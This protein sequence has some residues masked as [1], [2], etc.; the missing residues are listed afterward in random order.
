MAEQKVLVRNQ[1]KQLRLRNRKLL[2]ERIC[3]V[4]NTRQHTFALC[5]AKEAVQPNLA[6]VRRVEWS[7]WPVRIF[8]VQMATCTIMVMIMMITITSINSN[9]QIFSC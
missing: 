2:P 7:M 3:P 5:I 4:R 8:K 1:L 6:P 9:A